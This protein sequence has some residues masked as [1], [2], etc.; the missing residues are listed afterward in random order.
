MEWDDVHLSSPGLATRLEGL[1]GDVGDTAR[2]LVRSPP[3][4]GPAAM[5]LQELAGLLLRDQA[6]DADVVAR[7][8]VDD[9]EPA[10]A[11]QHVVAGAAEEDVVPGTADQHVIAV[12]AVR[13]ELDGAECES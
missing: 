1:A 12:A 5:L 6:L 7:S 3:G 2:E 13:R 4:A 9:V 11:D 10:A 8:A